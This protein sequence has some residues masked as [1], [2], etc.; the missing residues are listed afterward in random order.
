MND[1]VSAN[2]LGPV[3]GVKRGMTR[4][5]KNGQSVCVTLVEISDNAIIGFRNGTKFLLGCIKAKNPSKINK[6]Q[7]VE[8]ERIGSLLYIKR[9]ECKI[10][11]LD[12]SDI[13]DI[14]HKFL[15]KVLD[16]SSFKEDSI[17]DV[18]AISLGKQFCGVIKRH[19]FKGNDSN[20]ASR[21]KRA[22]GSTG[23]RQDPGKV[24]KNKKMAGKDGNKLVTIK[25]LKIVDVDC[26]SR[27]IAISGSIPGPKGKV[28]KIYP[29]KHFLPFGW[30]MSFL[31]I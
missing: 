6:P 17:V 23:Q 19:G 11:T 24:F 14:N 7:R 28:I 12:T 13:N 27:L 4:L 31:R 22:H 5:F 9:Y 2:I 15:N 30:N 29:S 8:L 25:N 21:V 1:T 3:L 16:I 18:Q 20:N 10:N 26:E